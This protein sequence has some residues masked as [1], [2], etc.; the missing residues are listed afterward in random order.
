M[1]PMGRVAGSCP[2]VEPAL[3]FT[4]VRLVVSFAFCVM[5]HNALTSIDVHLEESVHGIAT[6][7]R[8][9]LEAD[10]ARVARVATRHKQITIGFEA[11]AAAQQRRLQKFQKL[12]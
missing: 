1:E 11:L 6:S 2:R 4:V 5:G 7:R 9:G 12:A 8:L 10:S 3:M